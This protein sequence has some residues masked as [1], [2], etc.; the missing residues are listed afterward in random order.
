MRQANGIVRR[1]Y[2]VLSFDLQGHGE[3]DGKRYPL[4]PRDVRGA[5]AYVQSRS[6]PASRIGLLCHS[7]GASTCLLA[8]AEEPDLAGVVADSH[9]ARLTDLLAVNYRSQAN[10]LPSSIPAFCRLPSQ[11]KMLTLQML[12]R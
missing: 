4:G 7:M 11:S 12:L 9:Y 8:A 10:C 6:I 2:S 3:S 5:I 1:G